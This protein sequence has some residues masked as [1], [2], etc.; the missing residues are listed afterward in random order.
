MRR[1]GTPRVP[2]W[3]LAT[4]SVIGLMVLFEVLS[5]TEILSPRSFPPVSDM[6]STLWDQLLT[7]ELWSA[8][9]NTI[10]GWALGLGHRRRRWRSRS[11]S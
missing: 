4:A 9:G 11:A 5:R 1:A 2:D 6:L 3:A 8:I 10:Q 7:S